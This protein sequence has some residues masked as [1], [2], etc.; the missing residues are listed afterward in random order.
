MGGLRALTEGRRRGM[1]VVVIKPTQGGEGRF[2]DEWL[3]L[4]PG[5]DA[6]L[7]LSMLHVVIGEELYDR[8]FVRDWCFGFE[9]LAEHGPTSIYVANRFAPQLLGSISVAAYS[10]MALVP[11]IQPPVIRFLTTEAERRI[12]MPYHEKPVSKRKK[13]LF[14]ILVT[15]IFGFLVPASA[16]LKRRIQTYSTCCCS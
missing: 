15:L 3:A 12:A 6:A 11:I 13:V 8:D 16:E 9:E 14:P 10:Y 2:S 4:R 1:R 7:A 5:T